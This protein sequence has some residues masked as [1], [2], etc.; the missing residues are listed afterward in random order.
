MDRNDLLVFAMP[1]ALLANHWSEDHDAS[2]W[3]KFDYY[4]K[5]GPILQLSAPEAPQPGEGERID[6][7][8]G[9]LW[10]LAMH[11]FTPTWKFNTPGTSESEMFLVGYSQCRGTYSR[12]LVSYRVNLQFSESRVNGASGEVH[13]NAGDVKITQVNAA[14]ALATSIPWNSGRSVLNSGHII[15]LRK[16]LKCFSFL[17]GVKQPVRELEVDGT[18]FSDEEAAIAAVVD[19]WTGTIACMTDSTLSTHIVE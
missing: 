9:R 14:S 17:S 7:P 5:S 18:P 15:L 1:I 6:V 12:I 10:N 16:P 13:Y 4:P 19:P 3:K 2:R 8:D 11:V